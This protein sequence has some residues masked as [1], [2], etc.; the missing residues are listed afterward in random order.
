MANFVHISCNYSILMCEK[1]MRS[2]LQ[3][4]FFTCRTES[5]NSSASG[6]KHIPSI[7][8][9]FV[10]SLSL[11]AF[12]PI[13]HS[14]IRDSIS[15]LESS[16]EI[17]HLSIF[18]TFD[19]FLYGRLAAFVVVMICVYKYLYPQNVGKYQQEQGKHPCAYQPFDFGFL[20]C[21]Y[22]LRNYKR[23][24]SNTVITVSDIFSLT[25]PMPAEPMQAQ[26]P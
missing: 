7:S 21:C 26:Q 1:I 10:I 3:T 9:L 2:V 18:I 5:S 14:S 4:I 8:L 22:A 19:F 24:H 11:C 20:G 15:D 25:I 13:I 12:L 6:S 16:P 23:N 17:I